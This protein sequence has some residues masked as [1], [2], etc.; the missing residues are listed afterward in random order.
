MP[1]KQAE[2]PN[3]GQIL[4]QL[5]QRAPAE[6]QALLIALAERMAAERYRQ[7]AA[8]MSGDG[9]RAELL[10]CAEREEQIASRIESLYADVGAERH[11]LLA[12][13]PDLVEVNRQIFAGRPLYQ[14]LAIQAQGERLGAA[15]WR[16]FARQT[17]DEERRAV[18]IACAALEEDSA[19]A[20]EAFLATQRSRSE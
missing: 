4:G 7:W 18:F 2:S 12:S 8:E 17:A 20:L 1:S 10:A 11:A 19:V 3:L 16:A 9:H 6:K 13:S 14:Q 5:L 15:T